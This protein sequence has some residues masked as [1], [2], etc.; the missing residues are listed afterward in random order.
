MT[1]KHTCEI[2]QNFSILP[3]TSNKVQWGNAE[4]INVPRDLGV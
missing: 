3:V 4:L 2:Q 1:I